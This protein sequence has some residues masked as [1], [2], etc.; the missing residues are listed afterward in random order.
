MSEYDVSFPAMGSDVRLLIGEPL[1]ASLPAAEEV[2]GRARAYVEAFDARL[3]R[4]RPD[5]ELCALN[6][7]VRRGV[8]VSGLLRTAVEAGVWAAR[9]SGGLVDPTLLGQLEAAGYCESRSGVAPAPLASAIDAA[10]ARRPAQPHPAR[11]WARV[12]VDPTLGLVRR[13]PG[14]RLDTG[15]SGKG[16]CADALAH[17]LWGYSRF[18]VD[19][20]GD[21]RIGGPAAREA[22]Y[23]VEI[24][25]PLAS[26]PAAS[27][28]LGSGAI[29]TSGLRSRIW[30]REDGSFAHHLIDPARGIPA[31]T[32]LIQ[33]SA[34]AST[35]LEAET[36]AKAALLSGPAGARRLLRPLGG[37]I[38]HDSG[39]VELVGP[40]AR[41]PL[42]RVSVALPTG[43][44][45]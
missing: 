17:M 5:S 31:W 44:A 42:L 13:P 43:V 22:P 40:L 9:R 36:L 45:A 37:A 25:H 1:D 20:G 29:A 23:E 10:P 41:R 4:F 18:V 2:A 21:I 7:D 39:R 35:A 34:V 26:V 6:A 38:V 16:L 12:A 14:L 32:G 19:C 33:V 11:A 8:P 28:P 24:E 3:S 27:V 30:R 15:G